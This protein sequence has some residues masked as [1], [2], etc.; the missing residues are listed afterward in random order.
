LPGASSCGRLKALSILS[1]FNMRTLFA[2][3]AALAVA[4]MA[5]TA[6]IDVASLGPQVGAAAIDFS[7]ADQTGRVRTL[8]DVAGPKGTMLVFFRSAD[9]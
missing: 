1:A 2:L 7:L 6:Q 5:V 9:W 4:A 8:K 3:T